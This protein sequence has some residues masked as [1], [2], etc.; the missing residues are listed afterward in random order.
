MDE[1]ALAAPKVLLYHDVLDGGRVE[2]TAA[3]RALRRQ[4]DWMAAAGFRFSS[5]DDFVRGTLGRRDVV[6][7][8]DDA[9]RSF[10][11]VALP[12]LAEVG[13]PVTVY[14]V[15]QLSGRND[16]LG[17]VMSWGEL[18]ECA[19]IGVHVG[20]HAM[21]HVPLD[22]VSED[23]MREEVRRST[24]HFRDEGLSP[25][26]FAYPFGRF[27]ASVKNA[28][29][30]EGYSLAFTVMKGGADRFEIR[31]RLLTGSE[32]PLRLR[33][34]L[35]ERFFEIRDSARTLVPRRFLQQDQPIGSSRWD[36]HG[37]GL[38]DRAPGRSGD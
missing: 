31:R 37:F 24:L 36:A 35:S 12:V 5:M 17:V 27:N 11:D 18:R 23:R 33:L 21:T 16:A 7:T 25:T 13:A 8:F 28:V 1:A 34:L 30:A 15:S 32:G 20:C 6:L 22:E 3:A 26:T 29:E 19:R 4:L 2:P 14:A 9:L 10:A 38:P